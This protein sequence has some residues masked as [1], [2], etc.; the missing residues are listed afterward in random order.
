MA[1]GS[2]AAVAVDRWP[3]AVGSWDVEVEVQLPVVLAVVLAIV[4]AVG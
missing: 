3:L 1:Y 2:Y 4:L